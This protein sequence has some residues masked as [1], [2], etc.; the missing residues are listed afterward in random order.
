[1]NQRKETTHKLKKVQIKLLKIM[2]IEQFKARN[3]NTI[4][5]S[6]NELRRR[7]S[8]FI[9]KSRRKKKA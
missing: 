2:I 1:M 5:K 8:E 7:L 6:S 3:I 4:H 9:L